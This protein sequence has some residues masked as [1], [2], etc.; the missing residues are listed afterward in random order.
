M[1]P[2]S[3]EETYI[4]IEN[5]TGA[6]VE[7]D[8]LDL[9]PVGSLIKKGQENWSRFFVPAYQRG[10]RWSAE[11]VEQLIDDLLEFETKKDSSDDAFYCIQPLVVRPIDRG[12]EQYLEV[13]DGQQR[14]TTILLILQAMRQIQYEEERD[15]ENSRWY[16][17]KMPPIAYEIQYETRKS[18]LVWLKELPQT[19]FDEDKYKEFDNTNCD[20]S[21]FAEV[22]NAAYKKLHL[23]PD[24]RLLKDIL[25]ESTYFI[26]YM[27][28]ATDDNDVDI[29]DRLNAGKIGLNNAELVKALFLQHS[30]ISSDSPT[31]L[32]ILQKIA[33]EWDEMEKQLHDD[34]LWG[35]IYSQQSHTLTYD[36][37]IEYLLD[38]LVDKTAKQKESI[39]YTF[40]QYLSS[41][42][43]MLRNGGN[44]DTRLRFE[45][46]VKNWDNI[47][48]LFDRVCE[49]YGER[50]MYHRIGFII[51]LNPKYT[52]K[53]LQGML[54]QL[55]HSERIA[56]LDG[57]I[58]EMVCNI[59]SENLFHGKKE[60]STI[61]FL[62]NILLEDRR[63]NSTARFSFS[64][65]KQVRKDK[66]WD[67]EHVASSKD[68][69]PSVTEQ[70]EMATD[71]IELI[72]GVK[73]VEVTIQ[74]PGN[75]DDTTDNQTYPTK[76]FKL[77]DI[78]CVLNDEE[79]ELC[80]TLLNILNRKE[81]DSLSSSE[82]DDIYSRIVAHFKGNADLLGQFQY[83]KKLEKD[84]I[85]NFVLLNAK[86]NRSYGN[87][88]F[89]VKRRRILNDEFEVY[90]PVGTRNVFE[91]AYSRKI[92]HIF[93]WTKSDALAYWNNI[94][95]VVNPYVLLT[96]L[97]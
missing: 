40:N 17:A 3:M 64:D 8:S 92:D 10:Y 91:K 94:K 80:K 76:Q 27:P 24:Y 9:V 83:N 70:K 72:T 41:Y 53:R 54:P 33:H 75:S 36:S 84:F 88:I 63:H 26:W 69:E 66:G 20:Y 34:A 44:K 55:S 52:L 77:A 6:K 96:D 51:E 21:H 5:S 46:V 39:F 28:T 2:K 60:L 85:W 47:K 62:Y 25:L 58:K 37:R 87:H 29:F 7:F 45:W 18:S 93:A 15:D 49:W 30:N 74:L 23:L 81:D 67:Q 79:N 43:E 35:F 86:T 16:F 13:I 65:Y 42:R 57:I 73:P 82:F 89:P 32:A 1:R 59:R 61:L 78:V 90:T 19:I 56:K 71:V 48:A 11:Q 68:H 12:G 22:F 14:L 38:L 95:E 31:D 97:N 4:T 50:D